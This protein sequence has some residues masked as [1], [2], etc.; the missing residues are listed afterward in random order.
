MTLNLSTLKRG[1]LC[2]VAALA[3]CAPTIS[4]AQDAVEGTD[5]QALAKEFMQKSEVEKIVREYLMEN[6]NVILESIEAYQ[7]KQEQEQTQAASEAIR[8]ESAF[9]YQNESSPQVGNPN[10]SV[11][12]VEFF[13]YNCGYCKRAL[14]DLVELLDEDS[15]LRIVFK[16]VPILSPTSREAARWAIAANKQGKY[17]AYHQLLMNHSGQTDEATLESLAKQAGLDV[18]QL[19]KDKDSSE[20]DAIIDKNLE[21]MEKFGIRGTPSFVVGDELLRGFVGKDA[22]KEIIAA[23]RAN[24]NQEAPQ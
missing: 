10:A 8:N 15:D 18:D 7:L 1:L 20:V 17:F 21:Y 16:E 24:K 4:K 9:L 5:A 12:I 3:V 11:T 23:A 6:G 13:D 2:S 14:A 22:L 19:K